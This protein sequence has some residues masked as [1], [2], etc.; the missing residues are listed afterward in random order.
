MF[1]L[2]FQVKVWFQNRRMKW[3]RENKDSSSNS[4][5]I[6][7]AAEEEKTRC[8]SACSESESVRLSTSD[9]EKSPALIKAKVVS[10]TSSS[11]NNIEE[12]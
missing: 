3:K 6:D 2:H 8:D 11:K 9:S 4:P 7:F 5:C 1:V 12:R 10:D